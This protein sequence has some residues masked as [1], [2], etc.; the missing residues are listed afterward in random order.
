MKPVAFDYRRP[1]HLDEAVHLL[2]ETGIASNA[3][4]GLPVARAD[5]QSRLAPPDLLVDI[6]AIAELRAVS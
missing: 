4:A 6:T 1:A 3:V 5:A 2:A